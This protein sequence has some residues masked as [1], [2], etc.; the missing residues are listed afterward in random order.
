MVTY[1]AERLRCDLHHV[2]KF[3]QLAVAQVARLDPVVQALLVH[4]LQC[5]GTE[6][7][8]DEGLLRFSLRMADP[9]DDLRPGRGR[10]GTSAWP[11]FARDRGRHRF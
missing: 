5:P 6:A 8:R 2:L 9:A 1:L 4:K 3:T 11:D 7:G 10:R